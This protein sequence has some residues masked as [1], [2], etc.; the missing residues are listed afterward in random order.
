MA[1]ILI[2]EDDATTRAYLASIVRKLEHE[3]LEASDGQAALKQ[4]LAGGCDLLVL[5]L[6][7]PELSGLEVLRVLR[8][9]PARA[10]LPVVVVTAM[11]RD[12]DRDWALKQGATEYLVKPITEE[13]LRAAIERHL[14]LR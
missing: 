10:S 3:V 5:D 12:G 1:R 11:D 14:R 6:I 9:D 8:A 2:V 13:S 4:L 7:M